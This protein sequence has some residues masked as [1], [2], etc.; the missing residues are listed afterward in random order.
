MPGGREGAVTW[1]DPSGNLWMFGG[2]GIDPVLGAAF[3][4]DNLWR[5]DASTRLWAWMSGDNNDLNVSCTGNPNSNLGADCGHLGVYAQFGTP[6]PGN[7]PGSR[8]GPSTWIDKSGNLWL[9]GGFGFDAA[10]SIRQLNDFWEFTP[11]TSQWTWRGGSTVFKD[12]LY[13]VLIQAV[14]IPG[15]TPLR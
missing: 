5:F 3:Y 13:T 9:F 8:R 11:S 7:K 2:L 4:F 15:F 14:W 10:G 1:Y 6:A 12:R